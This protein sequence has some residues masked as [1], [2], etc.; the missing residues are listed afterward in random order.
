[1]AA[2][3]WSLARWL[4]AAQRRVR[5]AELA[6]GPFLFTRS[7]PEQTL[8]TSLDELT[9]R[10]TLSKCDQLPR[11]RRTLPSY[12]TVY[13]EHRRLVRSSGSNAPRPNVRSA[14]GSGCEA[15]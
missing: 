10:G 6:S 1:M 11:F 13:R 5:A 9:A 14:C 8:A 3:A 2:T 7:F 12:I 4:G 15:S